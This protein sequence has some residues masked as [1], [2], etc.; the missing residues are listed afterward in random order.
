MKWND[1]AKTLTVGE[2]KGTFSGML[3][4]RTFHLVVVN[5]QTGTG[6]G[7]SVKQGK[8]VK[9]NGKAISVKL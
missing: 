8:T 6:V 3:K 2:R 5:K 7:S 9:Y 4:N 1:A